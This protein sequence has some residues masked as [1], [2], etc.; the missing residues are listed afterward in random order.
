MKED[1][2]VI[3]AIGKPEIKQ[4]MIESLPDNVSESSGG[5]F[6]NK[7]DDRHF[8]INPAMSQINPRSKGEGWSFLTLAD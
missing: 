2:A 8:K 3:A 4:E 6:I 5:K 1:G 7:Y